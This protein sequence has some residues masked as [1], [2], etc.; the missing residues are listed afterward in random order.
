MQGPLKPWFE[1]TVHSQDFLQCEL[2]DHPNQLRNNVLQITSGDK[3]VF[4][5]AVDAWT[6]MTPYLWEKA[7][8]KRQY[9]E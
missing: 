2:I 3:S 8:I 1:D 5:N 9:N 7:V 4:K 6:K